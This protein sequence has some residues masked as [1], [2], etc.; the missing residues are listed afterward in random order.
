MRCSS[1]DGLNGMSKLTSRW[2]WVCRSMPSPAASVASSTRTGSLAGSSVNCER[3]YSRSS[4]GVEPW[5]T[6]STSRVALLGEHPVQPVDGVGVLGEHHDA[7]VGPA[8]A[9]RAAHRVEE[10]RS[11]RRAGSRGGSRSSAPTPCSASSCAGLGGAQRVGAL[12]LAQPLGLVLLP[13]ALFLVGL[14]LAE[15]V[16]VVVVG[17]ATPGLRA[18]GSG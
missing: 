15:D 1:R 18:T 6:A 11:A 7:L 16:V 12:G 8:L 3:M 10:R 14:A 13:Q 4:G 5:I 9:V 17:Q 2:Q